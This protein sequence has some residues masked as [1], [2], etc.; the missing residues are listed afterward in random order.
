MIFLRLCVLTADETCG[1]GNT[2]VAGSLLVQTRGLQQLINPIAFELPEDHKTFLSSLTYSTLFYCGDLNVCSNTR[3][4]R[5][6]MNN[7]YGNSSPTT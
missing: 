1:A 2:T 6:D 4:P 5:A 7:S 3:T